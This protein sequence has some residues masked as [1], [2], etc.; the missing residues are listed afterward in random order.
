[1]RS[2]RGA[3]LFGAELAGG[4]ETRLAR[5]RLARRDVDHHPVAVARFL[6]VRTPR[7]GKSF[8][9]RVEAGIDSGLT[10]NHVLQHLMTR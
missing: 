10:L 1:M 9:E 5:R 6:A 7:L 3:H 8:R 2:L 4:G